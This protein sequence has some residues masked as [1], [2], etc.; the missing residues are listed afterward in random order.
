[1]QLSAVH[2]QAYCTSNPKLQRRILIRP[3]SKPVQNHSF[4]FLGLIV[5]S[6]RPLA[7]THCTWAV[8]CRGVPNCNT[9][10]TFPKPLLAM[11]LLWTPSE[12]NFMFRLIGSKC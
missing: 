11:F 7:D 4:I 5:V 1:M 10:T 8:P 6:Q 2:Q 12:A 3:G 9:S